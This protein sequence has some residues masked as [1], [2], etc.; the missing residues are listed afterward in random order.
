MFVTT[1]SEVL[2]A[3]RFGTYVAWAGSDDVLA[4]R[5][6]TYNVQL[7]AALY[8]PLHMVEV[9]LRNACDRAL[10]QTYGA[11]WI[12]DPAVLVAHHQHDAILRARSKLAREGKVET[13]GR[14]IA[15]LN[16]GFWTSLFDRTSQHLWPTLR[17]AF[18]AKGIQASPIRVK[19]R[20]LRRLRNRIAHYEPI[21][22]LPLASFYGEATTLTGWLSPRAAAWISRH[23]TWPTIYPSVPILS[24]D[25]TATFLRFEPAALP[26]LPTL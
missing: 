13:D 19:L 26:Y 23:S 20:N 11:G 10:R 24:L 9:A 21:L 7:S 2:S 3:D 6:Y 4:Q 15:E 25:P 1:F 14:M 22:T 5:L 16:F 18:K 12:D 8:G 17:P